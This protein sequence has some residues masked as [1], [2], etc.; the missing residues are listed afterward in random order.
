MSKNSLV[1]LSHIRAIANEYRYINYSHRKERAF[2]IPII[3]VY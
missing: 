1:G 3:K 2:V